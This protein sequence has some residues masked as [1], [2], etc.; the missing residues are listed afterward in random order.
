MAMKRIGLFFLHSIVSGFVSAQQPVVPTDSTAASEIRRQVLLDEVVVEARSRNIDSRGLGN[1]RINTNLLKVAPLFLGE[2]DVI[3]TL[4]FLPGV[5]AGMEGSSQLNIRGGTNDQTLYLTDDVPIY[6]QNHTFGLFSIFN[7]DAIRTAEI[8][9]GGIPAH[10]GDKLSGVVSVDAKEGDFGKYRH[11]VSLG[12]LAGTA[13]SEGPIVKDRLSYLIAGRRSFLDLLLNG[14]M[15]VIDQR[16]AGYPMVSFADLNGK[17]TWKLNDSHQLSWLFYYGYDDM[18]GTNKEHKKY[19]EESSWEKFGYGWKTLTT[20]LRYQARL[21]Q[22]LSLSGHTYYTGLN[23]FNYYRNK[24]ESPESKQELKNENASRMNE[25][26]VRFLLKHEIADHHT[27]FYGWEGAYQ[28]YMPDYV[29][30]LLN[31]H[32]SVYHSDHLTLFKTSAYVY[33]EFKYRKWLFSA[34]LRASLYRSE[35]ISR[36]A[37]EPRLKINTFIGEKDK[38][39]LA[40]DRMYQPVHTINEIDYNAKTDYWVPFR[41]N[42]LPQSDQI[43]VGWKNYTNEHLTLS[44]EAY[45]KSM[46]NLLLIRN[47]EYYL[48]AHSDYAQGKGVSMGVEFMAE[49]GRGAFTGWVS[50]TL[51]QSRRTFG[52]RSYPFKYDAPHDLSAFAGYVVRRKPTNTHTLSLQMQFKSGYPYYVPEVSYPGMGLPTFPNGYIET[53]GDL[54]EVH[55]VP[56]YP[57]IRLK[58]Y[59]RADINYTVER[60]LKHGGLTWQFSLLNITNRANP[61]AV[62]KKDGRYKAF[63]LIPVLPSISVKR[64]F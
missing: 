50:Y 25:L 28:R 37:W 14:L 62:Y 5:S 10:Y 15:S 23:N 38:L 24:Q 4:Q 64:S 40:Y 13:A 7:A 26:G 17:L 57:N 52:G 21:K 30:K 60:K 46:R 29:Y 3:K 39:M 63:V 44:I 55:H 1:M 61:Y 42:I 31:K 16:Q 35:N 6:N 33:D 2:R 48:D 41:E 45:Y 43:S 59:F 53:N 11:S 12:L 19:S 36:F 51:S 49:Y 58:N 20:S 54:F 56:P 22:G 8:Y 34:G 18:G 27:F 9:K 47:L 32:K